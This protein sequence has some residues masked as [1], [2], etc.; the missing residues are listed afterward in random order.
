MSHF[1]LHVYYYLSQIFKEQFPWTN[2]PDPGSKSQGCPGPYE[3]P[4]ALYELIQWSSNFLAPGT[5]QFF[6]RP[7]GREGGFRMIQVRYICCALY[8]YYYYISSTSDQQALDP[9]VWGPLY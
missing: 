8:L 6:R 4:G 7:G 2:D 5:R 3:V 1:S 9:G